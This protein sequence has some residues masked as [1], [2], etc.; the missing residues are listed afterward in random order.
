MSRIDLFQLDEFND[1]FA[2][3]RVADS[4]PVWDGPNN[5]FKPLPYPTGFSPVFYRNEN[6]VS[7]GTSSTT[8]VSRHTYT[9]PSVPAGTYKITYGVIFKTPSASAYLVVN[10]KENSVDLHTP[11]FQETT[12]AAAANAWR[13]WTAVVTVATARALSFNMTYRRQG[14]SGTVTIDR[15]FFVIERVL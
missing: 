12:A 1:D 11:D 2:V 6:A 13:T 4:V 8:F 3:N 9:S 10:T 15:S 5:R 7:S 14:G